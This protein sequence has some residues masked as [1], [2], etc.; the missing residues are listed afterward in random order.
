MV[1]RKIELSENLK[2]IFE[3]CIKFKLC[4]FEIIGEV[5]ITHPFEFQDKVF[6]IVPKTLYRVVVFGYFDDFT[7]SHKF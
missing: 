3:R 1:S 4:L 7:A 6:K 5:F 2:S